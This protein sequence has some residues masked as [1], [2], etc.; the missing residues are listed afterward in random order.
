MVLGSVRNT[1]VVARH[2]GEE[3]GLVMVQIGA[4]EASLI[5]ERMREQ[6]AHRHF[7]LPGGQRE[8]Q[9]T[10]S[11]GLAQ[12]APGDAL[13]EFLQPAEGALCL[14]KQGGRNQVRVAEPPGPTAP[15][16]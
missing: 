16:G 7:A 4:M 5:V 9:L 11:I 14:A 15:P 6:S 2:G 10:V 12:R 8:G 3:F 13:E 1:D